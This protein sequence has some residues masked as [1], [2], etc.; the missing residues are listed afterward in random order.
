[1]AVPP[2]RL[3][4]RLQLSAPRLADAPDLFRFMGDPAAMRHTH[5][6]ASLREMRREIACDV[7]QSRK[8]GF[9][10]WTV[11]QAG[12]I[13]GYGGLSVDSSEPGYGPE[14]VYF[15]ARAAWGK[16]YAGELVAASLDY[17]RA[18][19][20]TEISAF[21]HPDNAASRRVLDRAG[22]TVERFVPKLTRWMLR[23]DL[24][25]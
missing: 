14:V 21:V 10:P 5:C 11:R 9:G 24:N 7:H 16:G 18:T 23:C 22:F 17:A 2:E 19:K 1:M 15:F 13:I 20:L 12:T 4:Q 3:T 8:R 25:R 6:T